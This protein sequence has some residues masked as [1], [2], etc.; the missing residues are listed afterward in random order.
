MGGRYASSQPLT[1]PIVSCDQSTGTGRTRVER[2]GGTAESQCMRKFTDLNSWTTYRRIV[3]A[4]FG[5]PLEIEPTESW[6]PVRGHRV[7]IDEWSGD[8]NSGTV[9]LVHGG[10]GN[11]R[12]LAPFAEPIARHGWRVL[13]PDLPGFGL[14]EP[15]P[16]FDGDYGEWPAVVADIADT[17][18][19]PVVLFGLSMGGMTAVFAAQKSTHVAGVIATTLLDLTDPATFASAA[20]WEWLG[21]LSSAVMA[22][23]PRLFDRIPLPLR[24]AAPLNAMSSSKRMQT[25]F[26]RDPLI[27]RSWKPARFFRTAHAY[28]A[29]TLRLDCPLL[30]VHPGADRWTPTALSR[31]VFERVDAR[32]TFVEL[33]N[34]AHLPLE[35][36]AF[37]ELTQRVEQF[38]DD[39]GAGS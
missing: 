31:S 14:T 26:A 36:P 17:Q 20:R 2:F 6:V 25:Y 19:G 21:R 15:A 34:G 5:M 7:R 3:A 13:A 16:G 23:A 33:S 10:G 11:G 29:A 8:Q 39:V 35:Q 22:A 37:R 32:K 24:L 1:D 28:P 9:I 4:E 27:G 38:L 18:P 30:L 12:V